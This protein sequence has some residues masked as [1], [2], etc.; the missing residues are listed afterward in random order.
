MLTVFKLPIQEPQLLKLFVL[1]PIL[2]KLKKIL[3][4]LGKKLLIY[5]KWNVNK[6]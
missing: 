3:L 1:L 6:D 5:S 4:M 2:K